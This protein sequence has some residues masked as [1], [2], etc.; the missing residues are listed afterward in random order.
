[1]WGGGWN[2]EHLALWSMDDANAEDNQDFRNGIESTLGTLR[3][4][5]AIDTQQP[6]PSTTCRSN[7]R[8]RT[9]LHPSA[10]VGISADKLYD[11]VVV[12][13]RG[14]GALARPWPAPVATVG[15]PMYI[16]FNIPKA[17]F[18]LKVTSPKAQTQEPLRYRDDDAVTV[19][20]HVR[21]SS[22]D[23]AM[24]VKRRRATNTT[25]RRNRAD[26]PNT[27]IAILPISSS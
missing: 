22:G 25:L 15:V 6:R 4:P 5:V 1:M 23:G 7:R 26:M 24:P 10:P 12:G 8:S 9:T 16:D 17:L 14:I 18:K 21:K 27:L 11:F 20:G 19:V 13:A 2:T 3:G